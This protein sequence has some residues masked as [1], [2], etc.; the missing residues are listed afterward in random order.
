[1]IVPIC[2]LLSEFFHMHASIVTKICSPLIVNKANSYCPIYHFIRL[3]NW[4][5]SKFINYQTRLSEKIAPVTMISFARF[6]PHPPIH[7]LPLHASVCAMSSSYKYLI[8]KETTKPI[9][10]PFSYFCL[11]SPVGML[12]SACSGLHAPIR[13]FSSLH[14]YFLHQQITK[15]IIS[16]LFPFHGNVKNWIS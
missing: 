2:M 7:M 13:T 3:K 14:K 10:T 6:H 11:H 12:P 8:H 5:S 15:E 4:T 9:I 16:S 1:M